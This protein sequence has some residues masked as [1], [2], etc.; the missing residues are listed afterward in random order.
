M[1]LAISRLSYYPITP[2]T[3]NYMHTL[4]RAKQLQILLHLAFYRVDNFYDIST[5]YQTIKKDINLVIINKKKLIHQ[6]VPI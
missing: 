4:I 6:K 3:L 2:I 1:L 5:Q